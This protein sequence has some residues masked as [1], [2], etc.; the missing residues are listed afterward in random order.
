MGVKGLRSM[1]ETKTMKLTKDLDKMDNVRNELMI[2]AREGATAP[3]M[4]PYFYSK[5]Q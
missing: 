3:I 1:R 5:Q 2:W 4:S